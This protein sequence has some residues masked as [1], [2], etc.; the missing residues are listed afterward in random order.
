MSCEQYKNIVYICK[1]MHSGQKC[2]PWVACLW[3]KM[4]CEKSVII[5]F[6]PC[7]YFPCCICRGLKILFPYIKK[8]LEYTQDRNVCS[9][10]PVYEV[11]CLYSRGWNEGGRGATPTSI[12]ILDSYDMKTSLFEFGHYIF[13]GLKMPRL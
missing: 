6:Y 5:F 12:S 9:G 4:S 13:T 1:Y 8:C 7:I 2:L 11:K 3:S 10:W